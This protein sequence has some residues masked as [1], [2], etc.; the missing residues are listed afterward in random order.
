MNFVNNLRMNQKLYFGYGIIILLMVVIAF[1]GYRGITDVNN[2]LDMM[3]NQQLVIIEKMDAVSA[4]I[5]LIKGGFFKYLVI[6][7]EAGSVL[8]DF[9]AR[10]GDIDSIIEVIK[11]QQ[12]ST[13]AALQF[14]EFA[15]NWEGYKASAIEVMSFLA[16][17]NSPAALTSLSSGGRLFTAQ[18]ALEE[19][20]S[21]MLEIN[22]NQADEEFQAA[23]QKVNQTR[24]VLLIGIFVC[25][26]IACMIIYLIN[27]SIIPPLKLVNTALQTLMLGSTVFV[28]DEKTRNGLIHR[29]D[30]F[31]ELSRSVIGTRRY[32]TEMANAAEAISKKDLALKIQP[33]SPDD[34]LGTTLAYMVQSLNTTISDVAGA[35]LRVQEASQQLASAS[36]QS[37]QAT[38]Q[39]ATTIQQIAKGTTQQSEAVNRTASSVEQ[40]GRAIEGVAKGAEE[41]AAATSKA[42]NLT[43]QLS[44]DINNVAGNIREMVEG[45]TAAADAARR[46]SA[47]VNQTL[48]GMQSI[49]MAVDLSAQKVQEMGTR[50]DEIGNIVTTI[51]DIASQ[52]N[53]LALNAAIEAARAGEAGKGFAVV[54]DEVRK[55][56]ERSST[57]T[58]EI[59]DL[60]RNIQQSVSQAVAAMEKGSKEVE[61][62][63]TLANQSGAALQEI[64]TTNE[65]VNLRAQEAARGAESMASSASELVVAVDT[66]SAVVEEN[67]AATKQMADGS[68]E[69]T[70][71]IE[72]IASVSEENSAAVEEVS[73]STEEMTAQ[74]Q[75]VSISAKDLSNLAIELEDIVKQFKLT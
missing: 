1:L 35:T 8:S 21:R 56:A 71:A 28:V 2:D 19:S 30:E 52:T 63:V 59:A 62:G 46:G 74:V 72:N 69:V 68:A 65:N 5:T 48:T 27:Q 54:A 12:L 7:E 64:L 75:E 67:T 55:L 4:D 38:N 25:F 14:E 43:N 29:K 41:Q 13:E 61:N 32:F 10:V 37:S 26:L 70:Q 23:A 36:D 33:K 53:L 3:Y 6:P 20:L 11:G 17:K 47:T 40:M 50:S 9:N 16:Y 42:F 39:I 58:K 18:T 60:I 49:K 24:M 31:G 73:A 57:S 15:K 34:K 45:S 44:K 22:R 51:E 66:V